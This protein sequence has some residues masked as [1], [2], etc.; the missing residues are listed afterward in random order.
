M[1]WTGFPPFVVLLVAIF[2]G[3][4]PLGLLVPA[5]VVFATAWMAVIVLTVRDSRREGVGFWRALGRGL[6]EGLTFLLLF[7][8]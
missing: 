1:F 6:G 5:S 3:D 4:V 7:V 2:Q 8:P